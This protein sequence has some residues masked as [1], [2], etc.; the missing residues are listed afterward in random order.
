MTIPEFPIASSDSLRTQSTTDFAIIGAGAAGLMAA[1]A[2]GNMGLSVRLL[3][4]SKKVGAKILV[5]G[6]SRCNVTNE[7][8]V[9]SRFNGEGASK[10]VSRI[11][12]SFSPADTHRFF[13]GVGV[14]LKLEPTGKFFPVTDS[15]RT[16]LNAL[17][18]AVSEAGAILSTQTPVKELKKLENGWRIETENESIFAKSVLV[19]TGGLALPKSGSDGRGFR[20]AQALGHSIV[21]TTPALTPLLSKNPVGAEFSGQ[22]L[23]VRLRLYRRN[24]PAQNERLVSFDGSFLFTHIGYSGPVALNISRHVVRE[25][26]KHPQ[27]GVFASFMPNVQD[28]EENI[29]WQDFQRENAKRNIANSLASHM[30]NSLAEKIAAVA[31]VGHLPVNRMEKAHIE[32]LK[33][34]LFYHP[35]EVSE[36]APYEKAETTAGG[37][38][39]DEIEPATMMSKLHKGLFFAGEVCDVDGWLGGYNFQWCWSS[40]TVAGRAAARYVK[41]A[42]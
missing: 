5:S 1:I 12:R 17:L 6:G 16:V 7:D 25:R 11:L 24:T 20:F 22:T 15:S 34:S 37:I 10:F 35:L 23:P 42:P 40:G 27:A 26:W 19:A 30:P 41:S 31:R 3:D 4:S 32:A 28:G 13:A 29:W 18:N 39:L 2:A 21:R 36:V 9:P 38:S 33:S 14:E 8:V